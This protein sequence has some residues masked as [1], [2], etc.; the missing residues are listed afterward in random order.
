[1][2]RQVNS[3]FGASRSFK[4]ANDEFYSFTDYL[5]GGEKLKCSLV[6]VVSVVSSK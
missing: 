6:V 4:L 1:M 5:G 3:P 2:D